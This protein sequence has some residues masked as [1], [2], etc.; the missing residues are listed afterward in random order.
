MTVTIHP[1]ILDGDLKG[2]V[3]QH[4]GVD[5]AFAAELAEHEAAAEVLIAHN[6]VCGREM[7][8]IY[9]GDVLAVYR[10]PFPEVNISNINAAHLAGL[11][12]FEW[13]GDG[14]MF[15]ADD[16]LGRVLIAIA[17][18]PTDAG[19]PA[20]QGQEQDGVLVVE[21]GRPVA[22]ADT[23]LRQLHEVCMIAQSIGR[24]VLWA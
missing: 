22:W 21:C 9:G 23:R 11:L 4:A 7:C 20:T 5:E 2:W 16:L 19:T 18:N 8:T 24:G 13:D 6:R 12:G 14:I 3:V 15:D 1:E 17:V 10:T